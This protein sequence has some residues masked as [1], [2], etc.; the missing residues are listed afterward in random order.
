VP[1]EES[2]R[3]YVSALSFSSTLS[4]AVYSPSYYI[5]ERERLGLGLGLGIST[6]DSAVYS[7][8]YYIS[9]RERG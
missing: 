4:N 7:P 8:S 3:H 5:P 2:R 9:E 6:L 1:S